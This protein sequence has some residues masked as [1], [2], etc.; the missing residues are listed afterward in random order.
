MSSGDLIWQSLLAGRSD[1]PEFARLTEIRTPLAVPPPT[2]SV[3][4][5]LDDTVA[6]EALA[7][8]AGPEPA[9]VD[10]VF[11]EQPT[12]K[13]SDFDALLRGEMP[14]DQ[15]EQADTADLDADFADLDLSEPADTAFLSEPVETESAGE[16]EPEAAF[17]AAPASEDAEDTAPEPVDEPEE[18]IDPLGWVD[19]LTNSFAHPDETFPGPTVVSSVP[20]NDGADETEDAASAEEF[21]EPEPA[22]EPQTPRERAAALAGRLG[23]A[24]VD[25]TEFA[26]DTSVVG[27]VP[28][29][30]SRRHVVLPI[31]R[32]G[33]RIMVAVADPEN[34]VVLDDVATVVRGQIVPVVAE[35]EAILAAIDRYHRADAELQE[36]TS[37]FTAESDADPFS[38]DVAD[39]GTDEAPIIRF[40]N[41][42]ISQAIVDRASDIHIEPMRDELRVRYRIDGVLTTVQRVPRSMIPGVISRIKVM[43]ELDIGERRKPQDGRISVAHSGRTV[44]LRVAT[45]PTVWGEK[46][47]ARVLDA[48]VASLKLSDL[49]MLDRNMDVFQKSFSKPYGMILVT[50]PTGS[51][52]STTLYTT[53]ATVS[54]PS[55]NVITVEDPVEYR[56]AGINQVQVNP[57][58]GMTFAAALRSILRSDP[59]VILIGEIRDEETAKI[60]IESS[61]TGHLVLSTLHTNDAPSSVTRLIEMGVEPFL[62]GSAL[63]SVVAQRLARRLCEK[64]KT[65]GPAT[66]MELRIVGVPLTGEE[67]P[68]VYRPVGCSQC[69]NT[70]Y[71]GRIALHEVMAVDEEIERLASENAPAA[72]IAA[73]AESTGMARLRGDGWAKVLLGHTSIEEILRVTL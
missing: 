33:E 60:A 63:D 42:T 50:G 59:D 29:A 16:A 28:D 38:Q 48:P 46:V 47:V 4:Q 57:K 55:I 35:P 41:L 39:S 54:K 65:S 43:A 49:S 18:E 27:L 6:A 36:L 62:V 71:R 40:V 21:V 17:V 12:F 3:E 20:G 24:Y 31:A 58:A 26:V 67:P 1:A 2:F 69:S 25:L 53:L 34:V 7:T 56:M 37:A 19:A 23:L 14:L 9:V 64:C 30:M 52:K 32:A 72:V 5:D 51:G 61:L 15:D 11:D 45:L 44:D 22:P 13:E 68:V 8:T 10:P 66:E 70:G 73:H